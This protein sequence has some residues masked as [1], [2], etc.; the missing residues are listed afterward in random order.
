MD[1]KISFF[2][3]VRTRIVLTVAIMVLIAGFSIKGIY[4]VNVSKIIT[5][6]NQHYIEDLAIAYGSMIE[7]QIEESGTEAVLTADLLEKQLAGVGLDGIESSY[8]YVVSP[9]GT[10]LYHPTPEKIG[11]PVENAAVSSV[12]DKIA[13]GEKIANEVIEYEFN[14]A[15]KYAGMYVNDAQD[16]ILVVTADEDEIFE[17]LTSSQIT[18]LVTLIVVLI[19]AVS[20]GCGSAYIIIKPINILSNLTL[21]LADMDF[22]DDGTQAK[23]NARKDET[24]RMSRALSVLR[25]SLVNVV[26]GIRQKSGQV[27]EASDAMNSNAVETNTTMTQVEIAINDIAQGASSQATDTQKATENIIVMGNMVEA[28]RDEV[29][30]L[31]EYAT[32]M[33][34]S[35]SKAESI[36]NQL[37]DINHKAEEYIDEI[38]KQTNTTNESALKIS[39]ATKLI[40]AI[41]EETNLLSLNASIEAARAG[42][43]GRGFAVVAAEIQ[44]LAE[45]SNESAQHIEEIIQGLLQDSEKAVETMNDVKV[46][47]KTQSEHVEQTENAFKQINDEVQLSVRG[48]NEISEKTRQLDEARVNVVD[49]VQNLTAIA[50]ENAASSEETSASVTEVSAIVDEIS[51]KATSLKD[52]ARE[53][54]DSMSIFKV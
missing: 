53:L 11:Q 46:I 10:M 14:G 7:L 33:Q 9:T 45:Q 29:D 39:E 54:E 18:G 34:D 31:L 42:E 17:P 40:T 30:K 16:Y 26:S 8:V 44:K 24:G 1:N 27:M 32:E 25:D 38:A 5:S 41:A 51:G 13:K 22:I 20:L 47:M 15:K 28:T 49:V 6:N 4:D 23:L 35:T 36:L 43:Q 48:I 3:S 19:V 37:D 2:S 12:V 52:I 50:E 21:R